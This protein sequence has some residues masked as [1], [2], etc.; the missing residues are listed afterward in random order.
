MSEPTP[1][2]ALVAGHY[3]DYRVLALFTSEQAAKA[4][5]DLTEDCGAYPNDPRP[6]LFLLY[7]NVPDPTTLW[8]IRET[9]YDDG[10]ST[11]YKETSETAP[12]WAHWLPPPD[13][14]RPYVRYGSRRHLPN[15]GVLTVLGYDQ[16]AVRQAFS[17]RKAM[18]LS[19]EWDPTKETE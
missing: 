16:Q 1:V 19:G 15:R 8:E 18:L 17:D 12:P 7:E 10:H 11:G 9:I 2:W 3:S 6:A 5:A 4:A 14:E 13:P